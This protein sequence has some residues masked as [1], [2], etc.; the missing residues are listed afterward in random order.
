MAQT[1]RFVVAQKPVRVCLDATPAW[2]DP[3]FL[4][5]FHGIEVIEVETQVTIPP[6]CPSL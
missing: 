5:A 1:T 2:P 3:P 4:M 6:A